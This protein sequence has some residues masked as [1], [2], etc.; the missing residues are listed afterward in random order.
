[1]T[2]C[3]LLF[4]TDSS[5]EGDF[6]SRNVDSHKGAINQFLLLGEGLNQVWS[7]SNDCTVKVCA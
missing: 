4:L 7:C 1:V 2:A 5:Q 6:M 3:K